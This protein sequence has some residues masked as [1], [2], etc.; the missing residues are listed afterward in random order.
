MPE[1]E[2]SLPSRMAGGRSIGTNLRLTIRLPIVST[3]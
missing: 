1:G 2:V 3:W